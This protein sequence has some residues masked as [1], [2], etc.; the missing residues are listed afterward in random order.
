M[1]LT[2]NDLVIEL[3]KGKNEDFFIKLTVGENKL[4]VM[5]F[6]TFEIDMRLEVMA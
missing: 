2:L 1:K 5:G 3:K 6:G 4:S